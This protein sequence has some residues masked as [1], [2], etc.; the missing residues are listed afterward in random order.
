VLSVT[1]Q[2]L[3]SQEGLQHALAV[4]AGQIAQAA[5][6]LER[7]L[8]ARHVDELIPDAPCDSVQARVP[9]VQKENSHRGLHRTFC[10]AVWQVAERFATVVP[11]RLL[12][13]TARLQQRGKA[14]RGPGANLFLSAAE[15]PAGQGVAVRPNLSIR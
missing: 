5:D 12:A 13:A 11:A 9:A 3:R 7:E 6:L 8:H 15:K 10:D 4:V 2:D 14:V 1:R